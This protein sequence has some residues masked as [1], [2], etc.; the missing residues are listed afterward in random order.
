MQF[1]V[2]AVLP[3]RKELVTCSHRAKE[4]VAVFSMESRY[5]A[6]DL[7]KQ[8]F[9]FINLLNVSRHIYLDSLVDL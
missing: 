8:S 1:L 2:C 6:L 3:E 9:V 4:N 7:K 5:L